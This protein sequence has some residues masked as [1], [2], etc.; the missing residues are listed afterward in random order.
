MACVGVQR[1]GQLL[2]KRCSDLSLEW[3]GAPRPSKQLRQVGVEVR[4]L[5]ARCEAR[6]QE[7]LDTWRSYPHHSPQLL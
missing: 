7:A 4:G 3:C 6:L 5:G 1:Q 2:G